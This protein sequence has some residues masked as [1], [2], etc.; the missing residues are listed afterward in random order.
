MSEVDM[1]DSPSPVAMRR[2][3]QGDADAFVDFLALFAEAF[4]EPETYLGA[5]PGAAYRD[6]LLADPRFI[7]L[8]ALRGERVVG[9]LAAY[10]LRK[11]ERE[12]SEF[13]I[14]DLA[15]AERHRRTGVATEL[16]EHLRQIAVS[17]RGYVI[18]VQADYGDDAAVALYT[19][20]GVREE[21]MHFDIEIGQTDRASSE[22]SDR[23]GKS[24]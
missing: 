20:L 2:L 8:A 18:F 1:P 6:D 12:R 15:V 10:E 9:A 22:G 11:F 23:S 5:Q 17:R 24:G 3:Q 19:K 14:Y 16:I 13:Y 4:D 21:V 7:V